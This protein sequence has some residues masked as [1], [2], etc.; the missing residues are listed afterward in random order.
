MLRFIHFGLGSHKAARSALLS[1]ISHRRYVSLLI[2]ET[3][4]KKLADKT[5]HYHLL[6]CLQPFFRPNDERHLL[7]LR[8]AIW[9]LRASA[10]EVDEVLR[11]YDNILLQYVC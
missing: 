4:L 7:S 3:E 10:V 6:L 1:R 9:E 2:S 8:E 5:H 11:I